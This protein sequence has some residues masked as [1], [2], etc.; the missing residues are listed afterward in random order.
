MG[1]YDRPY[2]HDE[3]RSGAWLGGRSVVVNLIIVNVVI[4]LA[5][6]FFGPDQ[7]EDWL[8]L[9]SNLLQR[10]WQVYQLLTYGFAHQGALHLLFNMLF[11]FF[12]GREL[13]EIYG[14]AEF[15]RMYLVAIVLA[16]AVWVAVTAPQQD[17]DFPATVVGAS[18]GVMAVVL[19]FVMN[20]PRRLLYLWGI[21]PVPAWA[22]GAFFVVGDFFGLF[23][24]GEPGAVNVANSAHLAGAAF[25]VA[26]YRFKWNLGKLVPRRLSDLKSAITRPRLRVHDPDREARDLSRQVDTILEKISREGEGSL[27]KKERRTLEEASRRYQRRKQ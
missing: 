9:K 26:Y 17:P 10:P 3:E 27:T 11:L 18:G 16:G 8:G 25:G 6:A 22:L 20:F 15:L 23:H 4:W 2:L 13:E 14:K 5:G 1:I 21:V 7:M 24:G 19:L 12:F